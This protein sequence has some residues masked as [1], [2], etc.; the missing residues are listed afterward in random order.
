M[1]MPE[2]EM[3]RMSEH[4][5]SRRLHS[6]GWLHSAKT[7]GTGSASADRRLNT[8]P[9][10]GY[11]SVEGKVIVSRN[12]TKHGLFS[13]VPVIPGVCPEEWQA[14]RSG[15]VESLAPV[16]LLEVDLSERVA[17]LLWRLQRVA[18]YEVQI[19]AQEPEPYPA[20]PLPAPE[21]SY[22][23]LIPELKQITR[24]EQLRDIRR[25]LRS[26]REE[27]SRLVPAQDYFRSLSEPGSGEPVSFQVAASI[28]EAACTC[29]QIAEEA[30]SDPPAFGKKRSCE[31][32][33]WQKQ[34]RKRWFG[35]RI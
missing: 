3:G 35:L 12:A 4:V 1:P 18:R 22:T 15:V 9:A 25:E 23:P 21:D 10:C 26:A 5:L 28:F 2:T 8:H 34:T 27:L 6:H 19:D 17:L 31:N 33:D 7:Q 32:S 24:D 16:G 13:A 29:A 14:H 20:P 11:N 30:R